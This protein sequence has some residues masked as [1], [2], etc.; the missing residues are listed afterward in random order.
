MRNIN[1]LDLN[2]LRVFEALMREQSVSL[3]AE[4]LNLTQPAVSNALNRLRAVLEDKLFVRTRHGMEPTP[5]ARAIYEPIQ[6]GLASIR[7][8]LS[9]GLAFD[10]AT[11]D[12][13]FTVITTD[14]G[15][16]TY[17]AQLLRK[18][19]EEA[20][21]IDLRIMEASREEYEELLDSGQADFAIGRFKISDS[22]RCETIGTCI[23]VAVMCSNYARD[24]ELSEG[25]MFPFDTFLKAAHVDVVPRGATENPISPALGIYAASRRVALTIPHTSVLSAMIPGTKLVA[26][27]PQPAVVALCR[28][29]ALT[30][31]TLPFEPEVTQVSMGWHKRQDGDKGHIWMR[32]KFRSLQLD[33]MG[34]VA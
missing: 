6:Q 7:A 19:S 29:G 25:C 20:P 11:S 1:L 26:T 3:A 22:F 10:P 33:F 31:A 5:V 34:E 32:E 21:K 17:G 13:H 2:L 4:R 15:E 9:E 12:R 23:Y 18:L 30:W 24:I 16:L 8:A 14:V 27:V 28:D